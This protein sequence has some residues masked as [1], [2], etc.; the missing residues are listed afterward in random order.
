[1]SSHLKILI[2]TSGTVADPRF[3]GE[4][5]SRHLAGS[6]ANSGHNVRLIGFVARNYPALRKEIRPGFQVEQQHSLLLDIPLLLNRLH[7]MPMTELPSWFGHLRNLF[8]QICTLNRYDIIQFDFP[9]FV[10]IYPVVRSHAR[11]VYNAH[12]I[13]SQY[14]EGQLNDRLLGGFWRKRL[15]V[16][17]R[18][19]I[20]NA[21]AICTCSKQ[22]ADWISEKCNVNPD[23]IHIVPNGFDEKRFRPTDPE[24]RKTTREALGIK[25]S[26][27]AVIFTGS[28][29]PPNIEAARAI[30]ETIAPSTKDPRVKYY[31]VG[32]ICRLLDVKGAIPPNVTLIGRADDILPWLQSAD[33]GLNPMISGSGSNIKLAE[34]AATGLPVVSTEFGTRGYPALESHI[35]IAPIDEFPRIVSETTWP[36]KI[37]P[38]ALQTYSWKTSAKRLDESYL[39]LL[40]QPVSESGST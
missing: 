27:K 8:R 31:I 25:N 20:E 6:L 17:E 12:N 35:Q 22:D 32:D 28:G 30:M 3:G 7:L 33:I 16:N 29:T 10:N 26:E 4:L 18:G 21:D 40:S 24:R 2:V 19:A 15:L 13:E 34:Y 36:N 14:W 11:I 1:M 38:S 5:R 23:R 9:W 37:P 39:A